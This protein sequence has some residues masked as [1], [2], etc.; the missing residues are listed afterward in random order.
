VPFFYPTAKHDLCWY[1][2]VGH[3]IDCAMRQAVQGRRVSV[4]GTSWRPCRPLGRMHRTASARW[5]CSIVLG[6]HC[7]TA[8]GLLKQAP[9]LLQNIVSSGLGGLEKP[10][11]RLHL[12]VL[13]DRHRPSASPESGAKHPSAGRCGFAM[14]AAAVSEALTLQIND[15][16][17]DG[18]R[19]TMC[20]ASSAANSRTRPAR[21]AAKRRRHATPPATATATSTARNDS[22]RSPSQL[23]L[24]FPFSLRIR[25]YVT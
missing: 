22:Q 15:V 18:R 1:D 4:C 19:R 6:T 24:R 11:G 25:R 5:R 21:G 9:R 8:G 2:S 10:P 20:S 13:E 23:A 17:S 7:S 12:E 3:D 14:F 16:T